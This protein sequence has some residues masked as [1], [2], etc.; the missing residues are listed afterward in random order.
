[1]PQNSY[2]QFLDSLP[3]KE[4]N[5]EFLKGI[6]ARE[7]VVTLKKIISSDSVTISL[8]KDSIVPSLNTAVN[9]S[10]T[11][12]TNLHEELNHKNN[13]ILIYRYSSL[14]LI[15]SLLSLALIL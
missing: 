3:L 11:E 2:S 12:I 1:M 5:N 13:V 9:K 8:Y 6:Q 10:K 7:R 15:V 14:G 4:L